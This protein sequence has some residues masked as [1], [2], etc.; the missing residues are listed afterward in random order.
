MCGIFGISPKPGQAANLQ[1][2]KTLGLFNDRR[3]GDS[4]GYYYA[5]NIEKGVDKQ[6]D[7]EDFMIYQPIK[8]GY[9]ESEVFIGHT[10][11]SSVGKNTIKNA[12]PHRVNNFVQVHNGTIYNIKQLAKEHGIK[13]DFQVD[14]KGLALILDKDGWDVLGEYEGFAALAITKIDEPNAIYLFK[15]ATKYESWRPNTVVEERPLYYLRQPE[16]IYFSS[17]EDSLNF[18]S[19][20]ADRAIREDDYLVANTVVKLVDGEFT[21]F[22]YPVDRSLRNIPPKKDQKKEETKQLG[23][24][25]AVDNLID[26][27]EST[28]KNVLTSLGLHDP[29]L[30]E[31]YPGKTFISDKVYFKNGRYWLN[32]KLVDGLE[33]ITKYGYVIEPYSKITAPCYYFIRGILMKDWNSYQKARQIERD[34]NVGNNMNIARL[35]SEYSM[36][37]VFNL[38]HEATSFDNYLRNKWYWN[39]EPL[40]GKKVIYPE[41][42][43]K[44]YIIEEGY[45]RLIAYKAQYEIGNKII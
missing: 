28:Q 5:G 38:A 4:C 40:I 15:G 19:E 3:G 26:K 13:Q 35:F 42:S 44:V 37:P 41:F 20:T 6:S 32:G 7:W 23:N 21:D 17:I 29:I 31:P 43:D 12:H 2:L 34:S 9:L 30:Y 39:G 22:K 18:I 1:K 8:R 24:G 36:Y 16:G 45:T 27:I 10:R 11:K 33:D 25:N 14:S